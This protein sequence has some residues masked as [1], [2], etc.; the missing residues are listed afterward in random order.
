MSGSERDS[1]R[2]SK[3]R[4][5]SEGCDSSGGTKKKEERLSDG[6]WAFIRSTWR[7]MEEYTEVVVR[8]PGLARGW[9]GD[10]RGSE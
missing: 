5:T 6:Q 1:E 3:G 8:L 7:C 4:W 2:H 10:N 9:M